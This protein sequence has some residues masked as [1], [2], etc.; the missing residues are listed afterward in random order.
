[1][2][3]QML[4]FVLEVAFGL[5]AGACLLRLAMQRMRTPFGNPVGRLVMALS[6]WAVIPLRRV[7]P[8]VAGWDTASLAAALG[9]ALVHQGLLM[10][11]GALLGA[12]LWSLPAWAVLAVFSLLRLVLSGTLAL[13]IASAVLSWM[14]GH[15]PLSGVVDH[16]TAPLL[17]PLRR[18]VPLVGGIDLSPLAAIVLV[19]LAQMALGGLMGGVL[20][21]VV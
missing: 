7:L 15:S 17:A 11:I 8:S 19:Q 3:M 12:A 13:L 9:L 18:V 1:M 4:S 6:N 16:L 21:A 10:A 5:L 2:L 14:P 20:R